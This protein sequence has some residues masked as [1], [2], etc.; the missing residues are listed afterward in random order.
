MLTDVAAARVLDGLPLVAAWVG[1]GV[2]IGLLVRGARPGAEQRAAL[3]GLGGHLALALCQTYL[4]TT[5][6]ALGTGT[7]DLVTQV[8]LMLVA[9]GAADLRTASPRTAAPRSGW[10]STRSRSPCSPT[11]PPPASPAR[12]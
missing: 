5:P 2:V 12:R 10:G 4:M 1:A 11:C 7:I 6:E 9:T 8:A 3:T